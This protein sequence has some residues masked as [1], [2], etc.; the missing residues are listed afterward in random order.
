MM[1]VY[2]LLGYQHLPSLIQVHHGQG[3]CHRE[4]ACGSTNGFLKSRNQFFRNIH[5]YEQFRG[6]VNRSWL[7]VPL[8]SLERLFKLEFNVNMS[9]NSNLM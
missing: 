7:F 4:P 9:S 3:K 5:P 1:S 6:Y 2:N 8:C